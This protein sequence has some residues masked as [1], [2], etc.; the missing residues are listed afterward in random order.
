MLR[1]NE[2]N[3]T[4]TGFSAQMDCAEAYPEC[5]G[6][7]DTVPVT[8]MTTWTF[9]V[10][11]VREDWQGQCS[12]LSRLMATSESPTE[13]DLLTLGSKHPFFEISIY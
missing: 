9:T 4:Y 8:E 6:H 7:W 13:I 1:L 11:V 12:T 10:G 5:C 2:I 3:G